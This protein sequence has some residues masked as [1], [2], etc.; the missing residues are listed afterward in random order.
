MTIPKIPPAIRGSQQLTLVFDS[1][2]LAGLSPLDRS[3]ARL[4][5]AQILMQAA[6]LNVEE[7][8]DDER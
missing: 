7:L 1:N 4:L 3:K 6:G 8:D 2:H 5:L